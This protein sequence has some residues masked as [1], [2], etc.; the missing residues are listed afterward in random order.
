[1]SWFR[2]KFTPPDYARVVADLDLSMVK[3]KAIGR[4]GWTEEQAD[5]AEADYR[6]F[7]YLLAKHPGLIIVPWTENLDHFWHEHILDTRRYERDCQ[8]IFG[9]FIHHDPHIAQ[10]PGVEA[11]GR[12]TTRRLFDREFSSPSSSA[13]SS[14]DPSLAW[15]FILM[16][17]MN[18]SSTPANA[19]ELSADTNG[20]GGDFATNSAPAAVSCSSAPASSCGG[21]GGASCGG[22]GG[23]CG[24]SG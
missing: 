23:G 21:G 20:A 5:E 8:K 14:S 11:M 3:R 19:Q 17:T 12:R 4:H 7:L 22:G 9:R 10:K 18:S 6:R 16:A 2:R 13:S 1:M 24:G 15:M